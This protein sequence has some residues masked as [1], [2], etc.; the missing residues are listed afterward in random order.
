MT[1]VQGVAS[2]WKAYGPAIFWAFLI[3]CESSIPAA[4]FPRSA[5]LSHDKLIH[6]GIY[7]VLA[8]LVYRGLRM[9]GLSRNST[10]LWVLFGFC[11]LYG[12]SDE[13]HQHFVPGRSMDVF[14]LLADACGAALAIGVARYLEGRRSRSA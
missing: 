11:V 9:R 2:R 13:F 10:A 14:D 7:A 4:A 1:S 12:A 5:I 6:M 8:Y 3:F